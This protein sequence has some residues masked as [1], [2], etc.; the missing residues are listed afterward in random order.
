[1][2]TR[3]E[4]AVRSKC[5]NASEIAWVVHSFYEPLP[6]LPKYV[7]E[8]TKYQF[9]VEHTASEECLVEIQKRSC[10]ISMRQGSLREEGLAKKYFG[11]RYIVEKGVP[12]MN[13]ENG[14]PLRATPDFFL[15]DSEK[16]VLLE[17]KLSSQLFKMDQLVNYHK[18]QVY[19]QM[20]CCN[21]N[22]GIIAFFTT[23]TRNIKTC[24]TKLHTLEL[25]RDSEYEDYIR[26]IFSATEKALEWL[27]GVEKNTVYPNV[28]NKKDMLYYLCLNLK[29]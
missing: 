8:K 4:L 6:F 17:V 2:L 25:Q 15:R 13:E 23:K 28:K 22:F 18:W 10:N 5:I 20:Y 19:Q 3:E 14:L 16:R 1:M 12:S 29:L 7:E 26:K 9:L 24:E 27:R 21:Y 11:E